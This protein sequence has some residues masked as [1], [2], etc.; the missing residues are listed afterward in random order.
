MSPGCVSNKYS[1]L[2]KPRLQRLPTKSA[3]GH[4]KL[5]TYLLLLLLCINGSRLEAGQLT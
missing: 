3:I 2:R 5:L 4:K 1:S